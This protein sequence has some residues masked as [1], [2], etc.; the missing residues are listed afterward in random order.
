MR[1]SDETVRK[2]RQ[3]AQE[4]GYLSTRQTLVGLVMTH[5]RDATETPMVQSIIE[6]LRLKGNCHLAMGLTTKADPKIELEELH[7]M[8]QKGFDGAI[9]EPSFA[10]MHQILEQPHIFDHWKNV[11]FINRYP[12]AGKPCITIDHRKC[13]YVAGK[14]LV[15]QGHRRIAFMEGHYD[16]VPTSYVPDCEKQIVY[17]RWAGFSEA[18]ETCNV[19]GTLVQ[20]VDDFLAIQKEVTA[21]YCAHTR[22]ATTLLSTCWRKGVQVPDMLSIV[23]QDDESAKA[24]SM[25][26]ITTVGVRAKEVGKL[27]AEMVLDLTRGKQPE[28]VVLEPHLVVRE[29]TLLLS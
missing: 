28:S 6:Q 25:P 1:I 9:M 5:F 10:L 7:F 26:P 16:A 14:Y 22:G 12:F 3:I 21:V 8:D 13:G 4:V 24:V 23:G 19:R 2:V 17:D 27:A 20:G 15:D 18:L 29:S 11:V